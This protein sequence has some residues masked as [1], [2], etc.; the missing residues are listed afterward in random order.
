MKEK[1]SRVRNEVIE[2]IR[3]EWGSIGLE[4]TS[5]IRNTCSR[6]EMMQGTTSDDASG[7]RITC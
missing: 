3:I 1:V 5:S 7:V 2:Y 6:V 4:N